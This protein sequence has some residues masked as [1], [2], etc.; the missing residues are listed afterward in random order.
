MVPVGARFS[1]VVLLLALA[2]AV[3]ACGSSDSGSAP[4]GVGRAWSQATILHLSGM[5]RSS[6]FTYRVPG[7]PNCAATNLLRSS[8]EVDSYKT[9]GETVATN[10]DGSAGVRIT[11]QPAACGQLFTQA[12][13]HVR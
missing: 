6:D 7:H 12:L 10:P 5:R 9:E 13:S 4:S 3:G 11:G 1:C 2:L 8:A